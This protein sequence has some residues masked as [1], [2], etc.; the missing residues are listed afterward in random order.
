MK[1]ILIINIILLFFVTLSFAKECKECH[2]IEYQ[3]FASSVHNG[4]IE[5]TDCHAEADNAHG[6]GFKS[7]VDCLSCHDKME[8]IKNTVHAKALFDKQGKV[9]KCWTCHTKHSILPT[10]NE[11]SSVNKANLKDTCTKCHKDI[12]G[13]GLFGKFAKFRISAHEKLYAAYDYSD[14]N[15]LNCHHGAVAHGEKNLNPTNCN[16][17]HN[18]NSFKFHTSVNKYFGVWDFLAFLFLIGVILCLSA[19]LKIRI[20]KDD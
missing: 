2:K 1:K 9:Y 17:C 16:K 5:C 15:C 11:F 19:K 10:N 18:K 7:P 20:K 3:Q 8:D 4:Q 13:V 6:K 12:K 14:K